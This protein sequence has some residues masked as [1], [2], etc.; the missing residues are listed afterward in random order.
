MNEVGLPLFARNFAN[1]LS[2]LNYTVHISEEFNFVFFNN[3]KCGCSTTKATLNLE[4]ARRLGRP[5]AYA[6]T[7]ELHSRPHNVL[8]TPVQVG[9][10]RFSRMLADPKVVRFCVL[11]EPVSRVLSAFTNKFGWDSPQ[12]RR[13]NARL[14]LAPQTAWDDVNAFVEAIASDNALRDSDEHW[15]LQF[16]QVCGALV[17][18]TLVGFQEELDPFL[19]S[20]ARRVF[21]MERIEVFDA[22][23]AFPRNRS[24][25]GPAHA[26][27]SPQSRRLLLRAYADDTVFYRTERARMAALSPP[28]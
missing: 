25:T 6:S 12:R 24:D 20:V 21:G 23:E 14:D 19:Q 27:L 18:F 11:R 13:F 2:E 3:P 16:K 17:D 7:T 22:R 5:L 26:A 28:S 9:W 1:G 8:K 4:C 10:W 15:R